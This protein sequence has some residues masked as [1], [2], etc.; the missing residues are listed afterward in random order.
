MM[1]STVT[2]IYADYLDK[3]PQRYYAVNNRAHFTFSD[4]KKL[5]TQ[6]ALEK[7]FVTFCPKSDKPAQNSFASTLLRK[8]KRETSVN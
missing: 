7:Y 2:W 8:G 3:T 4:V 5:V 6:A 1:A